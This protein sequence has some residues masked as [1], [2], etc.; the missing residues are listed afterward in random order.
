MTKLKAYSHLLRLHTPTGYML[1]FLP[2]LY[3]LGISVRHPGQLWYLLLFFAGSLVMRS[4]GCIINDICDRK[5]DAQVDRTKSRPLATGALDIK[6]ALS[7]LGVLMLCGLMILTILPT[8]AIII[9][10]CTV[11][12][13]IIYPL[14]KRITCFPQVILGMSF[15]GAGALISY[16]TVMNRVDWP[17]VILYVGCISWTMGYDGIYAFMDL[18]DDKRIGIRSIALFLQYRNYKAWLMSFYITFIVLI[19]YSAF[20]SGCKFYILFG[21]CAGILMLVWQVC[22]LD[23]TN[24]ENCLLRFK[25]NSYVG[26]VIGISLIIDKLGT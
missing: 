3:G 2:C 19:L 26:I 6:E 5:I 23:I 1:L 25:N 9:G 10:L 7:M 15:G 13:I 21:V 24:R 20:L 11:P 17:A 22:T 16:A 18:R 4:A 8:L 14:M 12:L